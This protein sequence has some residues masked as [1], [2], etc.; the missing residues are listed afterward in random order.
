VTDLSIAKIFRALYIRKH[1]TFGTVSLAVINISSRYKRSLT[2]IAE[3]ILEKV[4]EA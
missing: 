1:L 2:P 4:H 3:Y